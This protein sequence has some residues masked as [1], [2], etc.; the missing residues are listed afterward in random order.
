MTDRRL[1]SVFVPLAV[2]AFV[3]AASAQEPA[4]LGGVQ[5]ARFDEAPPYFH[6]VLPCQMA[7]DFAGL[8]RRTVPQSEPAI[9]WP[10]HAL[11]MQKVNGK[12]ESSPLADGMLAVSAVRIRF[13]PRDTKAGADFPEFASAKVNFERQPGNS[14]GF[15]GDTEMFY[16]FVFS[17]LC[18]DCIPGQQA[19]ANPNPAQLDIEYNLVRD[20][21]KQFDSVY[22]R[23]KDVSSLIRTV[24]RSIDEPAAGDPQG[25]MR[26]YGDLN[27]K[28]ADLCPEPAKSCLLSYA[29]YQSCMDQSTGGSAGGCGAAPDCNVVCN[30]K[31]SDLRV[32]N[33]SLCRFPWRA[34]YRGS[35]PSLL[36]RGSRRAFSLPGS[37]CALRPTCAE[38]ACPSR[39]CMSTTKKVNQD[40]DKPHPTF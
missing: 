38:H 30:F 5:A 10:A 39:L 33:A 7:G 14:Y 40:A 21:L 4:F 20:S 8:F 24:V 36:A 23:I 2:L 17:N 11:K 15:F 25:S 22:G 27:G 3:R 35:A 6:Y 34:G 19:P 13:V 9:C 16:K 32:L 37:A 28:L 1:L 29:K 26:L 18:T 31:Q 12:F